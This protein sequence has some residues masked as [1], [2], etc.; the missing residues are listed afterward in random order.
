MRSCIFTI[1]L[2]GILSAAISSQAQDKKSMELSIYAPADL[3]WQV[4]PP[5][6]PAGAKMAIL[7]GHPGKDGPF[8]MRLKFPDGYR[9]PPHM[10]PKPERLTVLSGVFNIGMGDT[11]DSSKGKVMPA[12]AFGTWAPGMKHYVWA[13]GETVVQLHGIGPWQI[14]Y[15]N[16][17]DDPRNAKK[18]TP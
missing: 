12:G 16:A 1:T 14:D 3:K 2:F 11:F 17:N 15:V 7:E 13:K 18:R 5:S 8:V 10:H 9:I 6:I 4:G